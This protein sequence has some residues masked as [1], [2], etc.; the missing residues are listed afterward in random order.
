MGGAGRR[1]AVNTVTGV[2]Q[3][4]MS[5]CASGWG[6]A[7]PQ[8][9]PSGKTEVRSRRTR[10]HAVPQTSDSEQRNGI[11]RCETAGII[12][13]NLDATPLHCSSSV[14]SY[15]PEK[16]SWVGNALFVGIR[17]ANINKAPKFPQEAIQTVEGC[18]QLHGVRP[19]FGN[20]AFIPARRDP[21]TKHT[22]YTKDAACLGSSLSG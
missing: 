4:C 11:S 14:R 19:R 2:T 7:L 5:R 8:R 3:C 13:N 20:V 21:T 15:G 10:D 17:Y 9:W 18:R 12:V 6:I 1:C 22:K 16:I